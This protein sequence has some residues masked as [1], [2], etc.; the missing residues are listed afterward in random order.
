[1]VL[2]SYTSS[3]VS[4][5]FGVARKGLFLGSFLLPIFFL[6]GYFSE[7]NFMLENYMKEFSTLFVTIF[8]VILLSFFIAPMIEN[9][10]NPNSPV[11]S[12]F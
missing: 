8:F 2:F 1:M 10:F 6:L 4:L 3:L 12:C 11:Q 5:G 7:S 9:C